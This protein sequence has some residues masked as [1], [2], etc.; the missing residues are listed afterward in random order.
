MPNASATRFTRTNHISSPGPRH[1]SRQGDL[2]FGASRS[3]RDPAPQ[4]YPLSRHHGEGARE[5]PCR[6]AAHNLMETGFHGV[7]GISPKIYLH[8]YEVY[9]LPR[10]LILKKKHLSELES[11]H[12]GIFRDLQSL[13]TRCS[14][15]VIHLLSG[16]ATLLHMVGRDNTITLVHIALHQLSSKTTSSHSWF[17][18]CARLSRYN[19][20]P[21]LIILNPTHHNNHQGDHQRSSLQNYQFGC[22]M[23]EFSEIPASIGSRDDDSTPSSHLVLLQ[24]QPC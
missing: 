2:T 4:Q 8:I 10:V 19:L 6:K 23:Q 1:H 20:D 24:L 22:S 7:N 14:I 13:P 12:R 18:Y 21:L 17:V 3:P 11:F 9:V 15:S 16:Q 5:A